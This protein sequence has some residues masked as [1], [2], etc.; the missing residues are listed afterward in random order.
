MPGAKYLDKADGS[1]TGESSGGYEQLFLLL[2]VSV[3]C[4]FTPWR[5]NFVSAVYQFHYTDS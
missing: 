4:S 2:R 5:P 3:T 1:V